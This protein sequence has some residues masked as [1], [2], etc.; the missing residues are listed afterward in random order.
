MESK[1]ELLK[2]LLDEY[3]EKL[4]RK[5]LETPDKFIEKLQGKTLLSKM[6]VAKIGR[7]LLS[8]TSVAKIW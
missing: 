6:Y 3:Q 5:C 7:K 4:H 8:K 2:K 1:E